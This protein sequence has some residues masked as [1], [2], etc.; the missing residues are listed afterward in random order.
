M[1]DL[2]HL[3]PDETFDF[4]SW[5]GEMVVFVH[6]T[7]DTHALSVDASSLI[8]TMREHPQAGLDGEAWLALAAGSD[9]CEL[10][11]EARMCDGMAVESLLAGLAAIGLVRRIAP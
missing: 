8:L 6:A 11:P 9:G 7:G 1:A 4:R 5:D 2:W 10:A 3:N